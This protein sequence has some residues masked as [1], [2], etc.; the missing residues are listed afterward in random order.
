[1]KSVFVDINLQLMLESHSRDWGAAIGHPHLGT[2]TP[3]IEPLKLVRKHGVRSI[4]QTPGSGSSF[5]PDTED[6]FCFTSQ[7]LALLT[8][9]EAAR[10]EQLVNLSTV[11]VVVEPRDHEA[12]KRKFAAIGSVIKNKRRRMSEPSE[13]QSIVVVG[14]LHYDIMVD[15]P[16]VR[17]KAKRWRAMAG[18]QSSVAREEIKPSPPR[19]QVL[20]S[21][22][23]AQSAT[24]ILDGSLSTG[25][26][27]SA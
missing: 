10:R 16:D 25:L 1:M 6:A 3:V 7:G 15:A 13:S 27:F 20:G 17:E 2:P 12:A 26:L 5:A 18:V 23:L 9:S 11:F 8:E 14:S 24:T 22:W 21:E 4:A 19:R